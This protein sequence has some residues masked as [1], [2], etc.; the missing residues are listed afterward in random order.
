MRSPLAAAATAITLSRLITRSAIRIVRIAATMPALAA[1]MAVR[2]F[3][4]GEQQLDA[5]PQQQRGADQLEVGQ[6]QQL[7]RDDRQHD[8]HR[9]GRAAAPQHRLLLLL[10]RQRARGQRDHDR[11]VAGQH[12]VDADDL[13]EGDPEGRIG[14]GHGGGSQSVD[15]E[16]ISRR[17]RH[18]TREDA[19][20]EASGPTA[21][22]CRGRFLPTG[23]H[24]RGLRRARCRTHFLP[25]FVAGSPCACARPC[26]GMRRG[27]R[28]VHYLDAARFCPTGARAGRRRV[29]RQRS[30]RTRAAV[31]SFVDALPPRSP[32]RTLSAC[33]VSSIAVRTR[34]AVVVCPT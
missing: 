24:R 13:E 20:P 1:A 30:R 9:D 7:D 8:P 33:S 34:R 3:L 2:L 15:R 12:D 10:G 26:R 19:G 18:G 23:P 14:K 6:A 32:V 29:P 28:A 31:M 5:D 4:L 21:S 25:V 27:A 22:E 16:C 11:V 17:R